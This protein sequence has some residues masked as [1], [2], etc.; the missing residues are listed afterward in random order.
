MRV[1]HVH[2]RTDKRAR[3]EVFN[4]LARVQPPPPSVDQWVTAL[5]TALS[6]AIGSFLLPVRPSQ[7]KL[8][9]AAGCMCIYSS[10]LEWLIVLMG[11]RIILVLS[12][13]HTLVLIEISICSLLSGSSQSFTN[14][15]IGHYVIDINGTFCDI[16]NNLFYLNSQSASPEKVFLDNFVLPRR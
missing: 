12:G 7:L 6:E 3:N 5:E 1:A 9:R 15:W 4:I 16:D 8:R 13:V 11:M 10:P 14:L 2:R